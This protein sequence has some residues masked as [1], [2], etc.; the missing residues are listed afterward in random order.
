MVNRVQ[1]TVDLVTTVNKVLAN[2]P[3]KKYMHKVNKKCCGIC[4]KLIIQTPEQRLRPSDVRTGNFKH[5]SRI[6][7]FFNASIVNF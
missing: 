7:F 1:G 6:I 5:F 4:S 2:L 3:I